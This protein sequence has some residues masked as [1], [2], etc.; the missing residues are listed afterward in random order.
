MYETLNALAPARAAAGRPYLPCPEPGV[1][2]G[3]PFAEYAS[4]AGLSNTWMGHI[5][6]SPAHL[7]NALAAPGADTKALRGGRALHTAVLEPHLWESDYVRAPEGDRRRKEVKEMWDRLAEER[8]DA[9]ILTPAEYENTLR[10]RD[11]VLAHVE[12][13]ALLEAASLREAS[14]VWDDW[15]TDVMCKARLDLAGGG[16]QADLKSTGDAGPDFSRSMHKYGYHRQS[17]FYREGMETHGVDCGKHAYVIAVENTEP[18]PV[19]VYRLSDATME[20]GR[21]EANRLRTKFTRAIKNGLWP[22]YADS[23]IMEL[24]LP[25]WAGRE[26]A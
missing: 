12:A 15:L 23:G 24:N 9:V 16:V 7:R 20:R 26:A 1:H 5:K 25:A 13:R 11:A 21:E 4:W 19:V 10:M 18:H 14:I 2:L 22:G 6:K 3:V 17:A 8:P